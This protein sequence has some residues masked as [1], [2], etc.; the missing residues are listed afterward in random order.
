MRDLLSIRYSNIGQWNF[1]TILQFQCIII[2]FSLWSI[3][4]LFLDATGIIEL[5]KSKYIEWIVHV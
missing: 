3:A 5:D 1:D 2:R 4:R